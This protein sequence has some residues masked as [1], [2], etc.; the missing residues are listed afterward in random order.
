M[1]EGASQD[2]QPAAA[3]PPRRRGLRRLVHC[4]EIL[5]FL[6][7][8]PVL[9]LVIAVLV[10]SD[11]RLR[12]PLG[13]ETRI[14]AALDT[15]VTTHDVTVREIEIALPEG[16]FAPEIV[17]QG[18]QLHESGGALR[19]FLPEV[20]VVVNGR[21]LLQGEFR[22]RRIR[23]DEAGLRLA[24]SADGVIDLSVSMGNA[25]A[26]EG[27]TE[28]L[29]RIDALFS[30]PAFSELEEIS[31]RDLVLLMTDEVTGQLIQSQDAVMTLEQKSEA[32]T[33][34]IAGSV[35][36]SRAASVELA[37]TRNPEL[38]RNDILLVFDQIAARDLATASPALRW[39]DL[40]RAPMSGRL[41]GT[42]ADDG[43]IGDMAGE[44]NI[45]AGDFRPR[46]GLDPIPVEALRAVL[47]F[48]AAGERLS[49]EELRIASDAL[50]FTASG[51]ASVIDGG[52][53]LVGQLQFSDL[54]AAPDGLFDAPL[55]FEGGALD[56]RLGFQPAFDLTI[57]QA[58]LHGGPLRVL[59]FGSVRA[60]EDGLET[61]IDARI[62]E[63]PA[64]DLFPYWP[65]FII[66][67]TRAWVTEH[68]TGGVIRNVAASL[69][70]TGP[71]DRQI[72]LRFDFE[73]MELFP[74]DGMP[75]M[76]GGAG[77]VAA[78][79][80]E[81]VLHITQAAVDLPQ[82][83]IDLSGSTMVIEDTG[84][85]NPDARFDLA[86]DGPL[87]AVGALL[88]GP[89]VNLLAESALDPATLATGH[90][91]ARVGLDLTFRRVI[92]RD[93]ILFS[94]QGTFRDV[95]SDTLVE[96]RVLTA[97]TLD[98]TVTPEVVAIAGRAQLD[99]VG[100]TA[101]W[102][103]VLGADQGSRAEGRIQINSQSLAALGIQLPPGL[104]SG[105]GGA[106]F[107]LEL[108]RGGAP[109]LR[110]SSDLAGIGLAVP[111]LPWRLSQSATG[112]F[113]AS[114]VLAEGGPETVDL[115]V[116]GGG[117]DLVAAV[118]LGPGGDFQSLDIAQGRIDGL[119]D[120]TGRLTPGRLTI[121]GGTVDLRR[122]GSAGSGGGGG[123][124]IDAVLDR[125]V[126]TEG[127]VLTGV[128]A[129]LAASLSGNFTGRVNGGAALSGS[130]S[131]N[132]L[133]LAIDVRAADAGQVL[134]SANLFQNAYGGEMALALRPTGATGA[135]DGLLTVDGARLRD[136]PA[137]AELLNAIS[138]VGLLEQLGAEGINLGDLDAEFRIRPGVIVLDRGSAVGPSM[139]ISMDGIYRTESRSIDMQGVVSPFYLVNGIA[140]ALF[141]P[142]REGLFGVT[143]RL[144]GTPGATNVS[145]NPLSILTPGIFRE[146]FRRPPP[147][148]ATE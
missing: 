55:T 139:G 69:R 17:L 79:N 1:T 18:V 120:I 95:R 98:V 75:P 131:R 4:I 77:Y 3:R 88:A 86:V 97:E 56:L 130:I 44:L 8:L 127:I 42:V 60:E 36:A 118:N 82:G 96:G 61:R 109:E 125:L 103:Q 74:L 30:T 107:A 6:A 26:S 5:I 105:S 91:D 16:R 71:E 134:R 27:I 24:R 52:E 87:E 128:S 104:L 64:A 45:G 21:A 117:L 70:S 23:L 99:G 35:A 90:V 46:E 123:I 65:A 54:T 101:R 37:V 22:P 25:A 124:A 48:D 29:G 84:P 40:L 135:Y 126:L 76:T 57:G 15:A 108:P 136:A 28:T 132:D 142:R 110:L 53:V 20:S 148:L 59:A 73:D 133:G 68:L 43:R 13:V 92:P 85:R 112:A 93:E 122:F 66:P 51:Q 114:L 32:L 129:D 67:G 138:V 115:E 63:L 19:A 72:G 33:L 89:P 12:L 41:V 62:T 78:L 81:F 102:S 121:A 49:F 34:R 11:N 2:D 9:A 7:L 113:A 140:G 141:A 47:A 146:I 58:V 137:M 145:V 10:A 116:Q 50:R 143:Y 111:G 106:D 83:R 144:T 31:G 147:E 14:T 119:A 38:G 80:E 100:A 94:A 39:L